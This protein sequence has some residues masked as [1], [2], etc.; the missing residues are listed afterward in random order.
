MNPIEH[1]WDIFKELFLDE[2]A[3]QRLRD[4][5]RIAIEEWDNLDQPDLDEL[6][7]SMPRRI[8]ACINERGRATGY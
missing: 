8:Q 3:H 6:V 7:D 1:A 4:L 5:R 2:M